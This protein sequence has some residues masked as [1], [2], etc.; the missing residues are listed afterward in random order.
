MQERIL[1]ISAHLETLD[2]LCEGYQLFTDFI[3]SSVILVKDD[4]ENQPASLF[5]LF[6]HKH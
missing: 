2:S 4:K 6:F 5:L 3:F 1:S